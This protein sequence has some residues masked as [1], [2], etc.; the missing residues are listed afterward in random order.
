M[1]SIYFRETGSGRPLI[2][3]HG[4][5]DTHEL[6]TEFVQPFT[7]TNH[8]ITP[9]LPGFGRSSSLPG[10]LT[11]D[12]VADALAEWMNDLSIQQPVIVGHSL[13]GYIALSLLARHPKILSSI[14]LFH[15]T[16]YPDSAERKKV[17]DK[18]VAFVTEHG[19]EPFI[20]T[21]VPG[22]FL[23]K[24]SPYIAATHERT[25]KTTSQALVSYARAMRE[26][27]DR[28]TAVIQDGRPVLV[29]A[30][31]NDTLIPIDDLRKFAKMSGKISLQELSNAAHMG[32]FE[33]KNHCQALIRGFADAVELN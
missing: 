16:P 9:D 29:I 14:V 10:A 18:V 22:L 32:I 26:R 30:G 31:T 11:I 20:E 2:F 17:R 19:V 12:L 24:A 15:S 8:V 25:S 28:S 6:W 23:D 13:G 3:L 33:A 7:T 1:P 27:P 5:C 21:F 4:F